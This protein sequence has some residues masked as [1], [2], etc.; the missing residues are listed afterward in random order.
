MILDKLDQSGRY[1]ALHPGLEAGFIYLRTLA[2]DHLK[3]GRN[4]I[5]GDRLYAL[6]SSGK[7]KGRSGAR[8]E[9]HQKYID[10]QFTFSGTDEIGWAALTS[11]QKQSEGYN[12]DRD[13]EFY[14]CTPESWIQVHTGSFAVFFPG[15]AHA[16]LAT[17]GF[18]GKVVVK[19]AVDWLRQ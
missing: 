15:D 1:L 6:V 2:L 5:D 12:T 7:G 17:D 13:I 18:A 9:T 19:I 4:Q 10:I 14:T 3:D 11:C 16:P 8:L